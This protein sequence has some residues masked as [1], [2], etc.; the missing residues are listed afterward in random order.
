M[1][2][3]TPNLNLVLPVGSEH[4]S[5]A[6]INENNTKIDTGFHTLSEQKANFVSLG[7]FTESTFTDFLKAVCASYYS[8][9]EEDKAVN[10]VATWSGH[11]FFTGMI[12]KH[13]TNVFCMTFVG[14]NI[15]SCKYNASAQTISVNDINDQMATLSSTAAL[16]T[17]AEIIAANASATFTPARTIGLLI[18]EYGANNIMYTIFRASATNTSVGEIKTNGNIT[19]TTNNGVITVANGSSNSW[20]VRMLEIG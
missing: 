8:N 9:A 14:D 5:R 10:F 13:G 15:V 1:S 2:S 17:K 4:V 7:S 6:I 18:G 11:E 20:R 16:C 19:V 12:R 3:S